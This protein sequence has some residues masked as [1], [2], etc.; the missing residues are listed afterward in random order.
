MHNDIVPQSEIQEGFIINLQGDLAKIRVA[1][2]ADCDNCGACDMK[3]MELLAYN[4]VN[5][6]P[7]QKVRFTMASDGM[8]KI[9]FMIFGL[10]LLAVLAGLYTGS[11][12]ASVL[13]LNLAVFM[14]AGVIIFLAAAIAIIYFYDKKYKLNKSNFPQIIEVIN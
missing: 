5:A 2:N 8:M 7:G 11:I 12:A 4:A 9:A 10:P 3:H 13:N 1:P 14:T 6:R